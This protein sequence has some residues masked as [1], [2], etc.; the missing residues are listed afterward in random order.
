MPVE[1]PVR[2]DSQPGQQEQA[3]SIGGELPIQVH[4]REITNAVRDNDQVILIGA[5]GS[6]KTTRGPLLAL[7]ALGTNAKLFVTEPRRVAASEVAEFVALGL[8]SRVGD[9]V[10]VRYRGVNKV[11]ENTRVV[12]T[13]EQ[14]LLNMLQADPAIKDIDAVMVDEVH[15]RSVNI[16]VLLGFLKRAQK[17]RREQHLKPLKIIATSAT[18]EEEKIKRYFPEAKT[19]NVPGRLHGIEDIYEKQPL[20][21]ERHPTTDAVIKKAAET[22]AKIIEDEGEGDILIFMPGKEEIARTVQALS[23]AGVADAVILPLHAEL[24]AEE[25]KKVFRKA[26]MRKIVVSTNIAETTVTIPGVRF[27]IDSGLIRQIMLDPSAGIE[28]LTLTAHAQSG[29]S[30]RRGRAGREFPGKVWHLYTKEDSKK[31][32][33][34]QMPEIMRS[35]LTRVVL[36]MK[37]VGIDD[38]HGFEFIDKPDTRSIDQALLTLTIL[39]SVDERGKLT[40]IGELMADLGL[41]PHLGRMV[42]EAA[43]KYGCVEDV[44]TIAAF[45]EGGSVFRR[46]R[47]NA[48]LV[49]E[50][51][52]KFHVGESDYL[53]MLNIWNQYLAHR[54]DKSWA[55][56][57]FLNQKTL[58]EIGH[59]RRE[60][61]DTLKEKNIP[62]KSGGSSEDIE[63]SVA[64]GFVDRLMANTGAPGIFYSV[65]D[66]NLHAT[67]DRS[68]ALAKTAEEF[69]I[70]GGIRS[71]DKSGATTNVAQNC[72]RVVK[73]W[74]VEIAPDLFGTDAEKITFTRPQQKKSH[75]E[76]REEALVAAETKV[77]EA[78]RAIHKQVQTETRHAGAQPESKTQAWQETATQEQEKK[79]FFQKIG[80][81]LNSLWRYVKNVFRKN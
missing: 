66:P 39:G 49:D 12:F 33:Q 56:S 3:P 55:E 42:V 15:E 6:G 41:E 21:D 62:V 18:M 81:Y 80:D 8:H 11:S 35:N 34:Y 29:L 54:E 46:S 71:I 22:A 19:I 72:Q 37:K 38:I 28:S 5:T 48:R 40:K 20:Y 51:T 50:A 73:K 2:P 67:V 77:E 9:A 13:V 63:K 53:T 76:E 58:N 65:L 14:S 32:S 27:V 24:N 44:A 75:E 61:L 74:L 43:Q 68:S 45:A 31:R 10:G 26:N 60:I 78:T 4:A 52:R 36:T 23:A 59:R 7:N 47:G 1:T 57:N 69:I 70:A 25:Q 16:D 17:L 79:N 64:A 30:Q